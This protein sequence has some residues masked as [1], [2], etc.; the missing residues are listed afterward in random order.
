MN[1]SNRL[2][3]NPVPQRV[4]ASGNETSVELRQ[5][6]CHRCGKAW[7]PRRLKKPARCPG[8]KSPYWD[9][10]RRLKHPIMPLKEPVNQMALAKSLCRKMARTF[11]GGNEHGKDTEDRS[12]AKALNV[13][14]EMKASGRT[15]Q[16]MGER[17]EREFGASL[18]KDQL[19]ALVR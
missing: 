7:W 2:D 10:P 9:R 1:I 12:L 18:E 8:C 13:L 17:M 3:S 4:L 15:W 16:E 11:G 6:V 5:Q 14:K 19:K